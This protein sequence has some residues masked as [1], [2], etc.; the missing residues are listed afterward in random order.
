MNVIDLFAGAGGLSEGFRQIEFDILAHVEMDSQACLTLKTREAYYY[1]KEIDR[2]DIY[3]DYLMKRITRDEF[4]EHIPS[5]ILDKVINEEISDSSIDNIFG[6][7]DSLIGENDIDVIIGGP[8][9][10]A[11]SLAGR[12]R[13]PNKMQEDPRNY[14]YRQYIRFLTKYN[15]TY[16][17]FENVT[18]IL[19][20]KGGEIFASLRSEMNDA[21]YQIDYR[22]LNANE[23]GVL[24]NRKRV[25]IIGWRN[26]VD[27]TYP[28][29][30]HNGADYCI[31]DLFEDLPK[32]QAG[33]ALQPGDSYVSPSTNY[34]LTYGIRDENWNLLTQHI[35]RPQREVDLEIYKYCVHIWNQ[36]GRK[37]KYNELPKNLITH[38]NTT[39][40]LDRFKVIPY[41]GYSHTIVAHI[42]KDGHYYIHPD[43]EQNRSISVREAARIQ[44]FPDSYYF[45]DSRTA[46][47]R[48]IGNSV[49]PQ[50]AKIIAESIMNEL[51]KRENL[52]IY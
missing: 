7:I 49:P 1:L 30:E 39:T 6:E 29:F 37:V 52:V 35:A 45:E 5:N 22:I 8:P 34:N 46:A 41:E 3:E 23:F 38:K 12:S 32:L 20:A 31:S 2:I 40:F 36:E 28:R 25:I 42:A 15:P 18:G 27:F 19:S 17:V 10:Q 21:G 4:Y 24:Q 13:D 26:D 33:E 47:F 9:C 51:L 50:M 43:I 48:Q 14:L 44:S 16:F 11:Y